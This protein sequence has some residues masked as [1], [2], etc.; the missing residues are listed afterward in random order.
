M[1]LAGKDEGKMKAIKEE[2]SSKFDIKD[3]GKLSY[4]LGMSV[5][6]NDQGT[7]LGQPAFTERLLTR[8]GMSDCKPVKTPVNSGSHLVKASSDEAAVDQ[9]LY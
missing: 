3:L 8:M 5:I 6:Q 7:W 9:Q 1:I 4:F 2:L